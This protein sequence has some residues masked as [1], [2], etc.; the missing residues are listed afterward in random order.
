[1]APV[2]TINRTD[3]AGG[4]VQR[5]RIRSTPVSTV[6]SWCFA[7]ES[8]GTWKSAA[9]TSAMTEARYL[10]HEYRPRHQQNHSP[11]GSA[12]VSAARGAADSAATGRWPPSRHS[13][14]RLRTPI[15]PSL[16]STQAR[17]RSG[18]GDRARRARSRLGRGR[19][20]KSE[21]KCGD[22]ACLVRTASARL[23]VMCARH[24]PPSKGLV[25]MY[26]CLERLP[27]A[28]SPRQD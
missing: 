9:T 17:T 6:D 10:T 25:M 8:E 5:R 18:C 12:I 14:R 3:L 27:Q 22:D 1:M 2:T 4:P 26:S 24:E 15:S 13:A 11:S 7:G 28:H 23:T 21:G 19:R 20:A 16:S